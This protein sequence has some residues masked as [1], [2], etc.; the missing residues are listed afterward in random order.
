[1]SPIIATPAPPASLAACTTRSA[2]SSTTSLTTTVAPPDPR[3][4]AAAQAIPPAPANTTTLSFKPSTSSSL[5]QWPVACDA[6]GKLL[7]K[8]GDVRD[9]AVGAELEH[10]QRVDHVRL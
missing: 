1:M 8:D 7:E 10:R 5:T 4:V 6:S 9:P 3:N 2:D